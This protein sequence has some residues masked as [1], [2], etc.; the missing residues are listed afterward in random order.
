[1]SK[2]ALLTKLKAAGFQDAAKLI[3]SQGELIMEQLRQ[4]EELRAANAD[5][6]HTLR[7]LEE[8]AQKQ[9]D[10]LVK[11]RRLLMTDQTKMTNDHN[12]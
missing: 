1:M 5:K 3:K 8:L 2:A 6:E 7:K 4:N 10:E 11:L 9:A 12:S